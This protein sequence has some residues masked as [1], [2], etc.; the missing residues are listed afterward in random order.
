MKISRK[1]LENL[2][3]KIFLKSGVNAS[4]SSIIT[5]ILVWSD[6]V[7]RYTHGVKR[8]PVL[9]KRFQKGLIQSPCNEQIEQK[10]SAIYSIDGKG[11]FGLFLGHIAMKKAIDV[12]EEQGVGLVTVRDSNF[13]G[14]GAYYVNLAAEH[15]KIGIALSNAFP[16]VVAHGG[17][18]AVFGTNPISF[19]A[20]MENNKTILVDFSTSILAGATIRE[21]VAENKKLPEGIAIDTDGY[22]IINPRKV[23]SGALLPFGEAKGYGLALIVEILSGVLTGAGI[24]HEIASMF[25]DFENKGNIGHFFLTIDIKKFLSMDFYYN[26][27]NQLVD[28]IKSSGNNSKFA[29][30]L[31][32]GEKRWQFY[33]DQLKNGIQL[34]TQT[35]SS[36]EK[37]A[38]E[39][40]IDIPWK[41]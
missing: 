36:V 23:D 35:I 33:D 18:K 22:P 37:I 27:M 2:V 31:V 26:R 24:S 25:H 17:V 40:S 3:E 28:I 30:I 21:Y 10:S 4:E 20:P 1:N 13:Y 9:V 15:L 19:S 7:G 38:A 14:V 11:G 5:N 34:D 6:L 12:A 8:V 41:D 32:P 16:K 39:F 29:E